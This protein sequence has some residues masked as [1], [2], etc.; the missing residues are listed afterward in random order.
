[1]G[2]KQPYAN[3]KK[4]R[5]PSRGCNV[6]PFNMCAQRFKACRAIYR[7]LRQTPEPFRGSHSPPQYGAMLFSGVGV[8]LGEQQEYA[9]RLSFRFHGRLKPN[10]TQNQ[11]ADG[12]LRCGLLS[13]KVRSD[14][15]S[16]S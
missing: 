16:G 12:E 14:I 11:P 4:V 9:P 10:Q 13:F 1:M 8:I 3:R 5:F 6:Q 2:R 7:H 15:R